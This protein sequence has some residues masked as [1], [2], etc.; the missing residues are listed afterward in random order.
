MVTITQCSTSTSIWQPWFVSL[1]SM[2]FNAL[3][4]FNNITPLSVTQ[5]NTMSNTL[6]CTTL[7]VLQPSDK[8]SLQFEHYFRITYKL[9]HLR[10]SYI[11][12][13]KLE[14]DGLHLLL[15]HYCLVL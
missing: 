3:N 5:S 6:L 13:I 8:I 2:A 1:F 12:I 10:P 7:P 9:Q 11:L 15:F 14:F 4:V